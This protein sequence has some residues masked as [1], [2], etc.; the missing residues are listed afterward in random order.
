MVELFT[1]RADLREHVQRAEA[2]MH[3]AIQRSDE[4]VEQRR[5]REALLE[6]KPAIW[7]LIIA[8]VGTALQVVGNL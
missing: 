3:S 1:G 6:L 5:K 2:T 7:W 4:E 8:A